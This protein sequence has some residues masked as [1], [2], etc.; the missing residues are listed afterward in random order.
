MG[1]RGEP[2]KGTQDDEG[3]TVNQAKDMVFDLIDAD[4]SMKLTTDEMEAFFDG[5]GPMLLGK[6]VSKMSAKEKKKVIKRVFKRLDKDKD[7]MINKKE[8]A[9]GDGGF[10]EEL[11]H[12]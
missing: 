7:K 2:E 12:R 3:M 1:A 11:L 9:S 4:K 5:M 6:M 10:M 8:A